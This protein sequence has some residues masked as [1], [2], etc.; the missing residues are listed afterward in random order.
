M[1]CR[2]IEKSRNVHSH[3]IYLHFYCKRSPK[4]SLVHH[5]ELRAHND[6]IKNDNEQKSISGELKVKFPFNE[7]VEISDKSRR[8]QQT[9]FLD[10][11]LRLFLEIIQIYD[12][13][14]NHFQFCKIESFIFHHVESE[15]PSE[16]KDLR[17]CECS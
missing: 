16:M 6:P 4:A 3:E 8:G 17:V 13:G 2:S 5:N 10:S 15:F 11:V 7:I 9:S 14:A 12:I 1:K